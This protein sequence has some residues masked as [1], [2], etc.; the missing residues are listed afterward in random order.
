MALITFLMPDAHCEHPVGGYKVVFEYANRLVNSGHAVNI[1]FPQQYKLITNSIVD[2]LKN[3]Y[4]K[5]KIKPRYTPGEKVPCNWFEVDEKVNMFAIRSLD[6]KC[7]PASDIYIATYY[8]TAYAL[9]QVSS[10]RKYYLVQ[11]LDYFYE[12]EKDIVLRSYSLDMQII[13]ISEYLQS[14]CKEYARREVLL[15]HN[16]FDFNYF[17]QSR[18]EEQR[19]PKAILAMYHPGE[20]KGFKETTEALKIVLQQYPDLNINFFGAYPDPQLPDLKYNY[21]RSPDRALH[22]KLYNDAALYVT[23][24]KNEGWGLPVGEAMICGACVVCSDIGGFDTMAVNNET[25]LV[26]A[27]GNVEQMAEKI[28]FAL[29]NNEERIRIARNGNEFIKRFTWESSFRKLIEILNLS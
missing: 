9:E 12:S 19:D 22:N 23:H 25:A 7:L 26:F 18:S 14:V 10:S 5:L 15:L 1:V 17:R 8:T 24:S 2:K 6:T 4:L 21:S 20:W 13:A 3:I 11:A 27:V 29:E 16:G 28:I